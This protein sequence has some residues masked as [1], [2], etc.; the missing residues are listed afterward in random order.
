MEHLIFHH[1]GREYTVYD[2]LTS[3]EIAAIMTMNEER[4]RKLDAL[5]SKSTKKYFQDTDRMVLTIQ[6][7]CFRMTD[8]QIAG[9]GQV[10]ARSLT[11]A[12]IKFVAAANNLSSNR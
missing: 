11:S 8:K 3:G 10:E 7:R 9:M 6:R 12:F 4:F 1:N 2:A 5:N